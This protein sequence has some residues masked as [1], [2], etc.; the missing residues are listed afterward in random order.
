MTT[1]TKRGKNVYMTNE[2]IR[3]K[4]AKYRAWKSYMATMTKD[5]RNQI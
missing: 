2:A 1:P 4:N 3:L 5:D